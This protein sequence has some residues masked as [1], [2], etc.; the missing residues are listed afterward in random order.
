MGVALGGEV[1]RAVAFGTGVL[2]LGRGVAVGGGR[3]GR[4][5]SRLAGFKDTGVGGGDGGAV[6]PQAAPSMS[7]SRRTERRIDA[8]WQHIIPCRVHCTAPRPGS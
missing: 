8:D 3:V 5:V 4:G 1:G 6:G 7:T 2:G